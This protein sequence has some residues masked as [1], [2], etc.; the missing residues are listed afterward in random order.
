MNYFDSDSIR[1]PFVKDSYNEAAKLYDEGEYLK[2]TRPLVEA[3]DEQWES[4]YGSF[5]AVGGVD[6]DFDDDPKLQSIIDEINSSAHYLEERLKEFQLLLIRKEH[7][8]LREYV[9]SDT[10]A[11]YYI[12]QMTSSDI[13]KL[14]IQI[15]EFIAETDSELVEPYLK[16]RIKHYE[17]IQANS[18]WLDDFM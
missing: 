17:Q 6:L 9:H 10:F 7:L 11:Y 1:N 2:A 14:K 18:K 16:K 3:F 15:E 12:Q 13:S 4:V 5:L 8:T